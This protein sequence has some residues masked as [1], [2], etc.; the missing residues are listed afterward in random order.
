VSR[1]PQ[2]DLLIA[3]QGPLE[4]QLRQQAVQLGIAN[5]LHFVGWRSDI[6]ALLAA[7]DLLVLTS[8]SE[9]MPNVVL[10]AMAAARPVVATDIHGLRELLGD[11]PQQVVP[12]DD[13]AA[14]VDAVTLLVGDRTLSSQVGLR[15]RER[16][17]TRF[18]LDATAAAY[19]TL[20]ES[21]LAPK[22]SKKTA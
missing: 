12:P 2:H 4:G 15:N 8:A 5:R 11:D 14:F 20:Y 22:P 6:P 3:G 18:S 7:A 21:L 19:A 9:G 10:E 13:V 1:L 17:L 16:A